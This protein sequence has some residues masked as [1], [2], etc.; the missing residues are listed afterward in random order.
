MYIT[1]TISKVFMSVSEG[2]GAFIVCK[3][4]RK[5]SLVTKPL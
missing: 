1:I 3:I 2:S 4:S 5:S